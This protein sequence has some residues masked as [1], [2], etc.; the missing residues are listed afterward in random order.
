MPQIL[1]PA[2]E[3]LLDQ[4]VALSATIRPMTAA[5]G[6]PPRSATP[7]PLQQV[8]GVGP[9]TSMAFALTIEEPTRFDDSRRVGSWVGLCPRSQASGDKASSSGS[10]SRATAT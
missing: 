2:V 7:R 9:L 10:A 6:R 1:L 5:S 4:I 3:P 8:H